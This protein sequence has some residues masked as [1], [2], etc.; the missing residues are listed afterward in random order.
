V[1]DE[2]Y[3]RRKAKWD[4]LAPTWIDTGAPASPSKGDIQNYN[5]LL[6]EIVNQTDVAKIMVLGCTPALRNMLA[7]M[8]GFIHLEVVCVDF[9]EA[10]YRRTTEFV[11]HKN[12]HERLVLADWLTMD[13]ANGKFDAIIGDKVIDNIMP[14]DWT[15]FF[16]RIHFHLRPHGYFIVRLAPQNIALEGVTFLELLNKWANLY[17]LNGNFENIVSGFWEELLGASAFKDGI[18]YYTQKI[19]RFVVDVDS[20]R[21]RRDLL[22]EFSLKLFDEF[23][24][25]FWDSRE[26]QW[27]SYDYEQIVNLMGGLF[28]HDK[29]LYCTDYEVA[30]RQPIVRMKAS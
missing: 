14:D 21:Q 19:G 5:E 17:K 4:K 15:A 28:I 6:R 22:D 8:A 27:S 20:I 1:S 2:L 10:M 11:E 16:Q 30:H 12:T 3:Q 26:D 29:T 25:L 24:R 9:S 7:E 13:F 23:I 18:R